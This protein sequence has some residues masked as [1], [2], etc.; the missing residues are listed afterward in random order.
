LSGSAD[1]D[2]SPWLRQFSGG[3]YFFPALVFFLALARFCFPRNFTILA[4]NE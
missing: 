2:D 1:P 4:T 3:G